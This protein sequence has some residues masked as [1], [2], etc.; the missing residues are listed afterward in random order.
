[1]GGAARVGADEQPRPDRPRGQLRERELEHLDVVG[2]CVG[3]RVSRAAT[4]RRAPPRC[5]PRSRAAGG[6]RNR[7]CSSPAACSFSEWA[8]TSVASRS[9][10]TRSGAPASS[11]T[12]RARAVAPFRAHRRHP[13]TR[14]SAASARQAV[15][16][17]GRGPQTTSAGRA[18]R[19]DRPD[20][21][22]RRRPSPPDRATSAPD[23][24][25]SGARRTPRHRL[26]KRPG[27]T[28]PIGQTDQQ[29]R[30]STRREP[31]PRPPRFVRSRPSFERF[32]HMVILLSRE[33]RTRQ[34]RSSL[35]RR[36]SPPPRRSPLLNDTR[37]NS[38][39]VFHFLRLSGASRRTRPP[40]A[41]GHKHA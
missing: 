7:A 32:T 31:D 12:T 2:G 24:D 10:T 36:T 11:P 26:R 37:V 16:S 33:T 4:P 8:V 34:P 6:S 21:R 20:S 29:R 5:S 15:A 17:D 35:L 28:D 40:R 19:S 38:S 30:A 25:A 23:R 22:H 39:R 9:R 13:L 14:S 3:T 1:M 41:R 27:Q 18:A